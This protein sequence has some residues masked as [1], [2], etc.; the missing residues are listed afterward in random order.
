MLT[1]LFTV[2]STHV[3]YKSAAPTMRAF[4]FPTVCTCIAIVGRGDQ[5][6]IGLEVVEV[7]G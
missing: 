4:L 7:P 5:R 2:D 1:G 3:L 6:E